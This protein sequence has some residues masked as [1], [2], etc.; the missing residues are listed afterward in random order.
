MK[1]AQKPNQLLLF[2]YRNK[3]EVPQVKSKIKST[4][5]QLG[6][7]LHTI[8]IHLHR[9]AASAFKGP[10]HPVLAN[11]SLPCQECRASEVQEPHN[12]WATGA[13][14]LYERKETDTHTHCRQMT[15]GA[16]THM[17]NKCRTHNIVQVTIFL[18]IP[19][20]Y[21]GLFIMIIL[22]H[23]FLVLLHP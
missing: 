9:Q 16:A 18:L 7:C 4:V 5:S 17:N 13:L 10:P 2:H 20:L 11:P 8:V 3:A 14:P 23:R 12:L 19:M 15:V 21:H 1:R 6:R 22:S